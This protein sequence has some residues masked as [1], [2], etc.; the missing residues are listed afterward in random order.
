MAS[1]GPPLVPI[2]PPGGLSISSSS[3]TGGNT[4]ATTAPIYFAPQQGNQD[5][6]MATNVAT[7]ASTSPT[8]SDSTSVSAES[9]RSALAGKLASYVIILEY[10]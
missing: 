4:V 5:V 2:N 1:G 8:P 3:L 7:S 9:G 6:M 10:R